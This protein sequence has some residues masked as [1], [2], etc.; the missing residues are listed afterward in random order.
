MQNHYSKKLT[1]YHV[2][3]IDIV[4][5]SLK[6]GKVMVIPYDDCSAS[7][8]PF[9]PPLTIILHLLPYFFALFWDFYGNKRP[10]QK[11]MS[12]ASRFFL[13][14]GKII[15]PYFFFLNFFIRKKWLY[16]YHIAYH[17]SNLHGNIFHFLISKPILSVFSIF[18]VN[19]HQTS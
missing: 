8:G 4:Y 16:Y 19:S 18:V 14:F 2:I 11:V 10:F 5:Q 3:T 13:V 6:I 1:H 7:L 9:L 15:A 17:M 12:S